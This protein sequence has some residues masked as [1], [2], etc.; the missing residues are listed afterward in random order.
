METQPELCTSAKGARPVRRTAVLHPFIFAVWPVLFV[1]SINAEF[2]R[3][4][5]AWIALLVVLG[6]AILLLLPLTA[7]LRNLRKAGAIVSL[8]L[9]LFFS[10]A[11]VYGLLWRDLP[12]YSPS[13]E[14]V[15]LLIVWALL[16]A[17][18]TA[19]AMAVRNGW[20]E[21]TTVL[22]VMSI[23]LILMSVATVGLHE[24]RA[25][26]SGQRVAQTL[27]IAEIHPVD[28]TS[29]PN[30]YYIILDSYARE[31]ILRET[32]AY[33]NS[34]FSDFLEQRGFFV[35]DLSLANY[36]QTDLSVASSLNLG[37]LDE[38]AATLGPDTRDR[39]PLEGMIQDS[40]VVRFLKLQ[41]YTVV[42]LASGYSVTDLRTSDVHISPRRSWNELEIRLLCSTPIPWLATRGTVF[43]PYAVHREK[44]LYTLDHLTNTTQPSPPYFVF[45]HVLAPHGPFVFDQQGNPVQPRGQFDLRDPIVYEEDQTAVEEIKGYTEQLTFVTNKIRTVIDTLLSQSSRPTVIILQGDHGPGHISTAK[46]AN[47]ILTRLAILNALLLPGQG[48]QDLYEEIT[49]VNT[50]RLIFDKYFGTDLEL[51]EDRS[52]FSSWERPY[53]FRD[54]T[55]QVRSYEAT[56]PSQ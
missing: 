30:I 5:Q 24:F 22:N 13:K 12:A 16:F 48:A 3:F 44:I 11:H 28:V 34:E 35:A 18:G 4:S 25:K 33:D 52:Y 51:L 38:L 15:A 21:I 47:G 32:Y 19:L 17:G 50:F 56:L 2:I 42:A 26:T 1:Y 27:P 36:P 45:A 46:D 6:L 41:G 14:S 43:D 8:F 49:P 20:Q 39:R 53:E 29:F 55:Y 31:D 9:I 37:Y 10:Y 23:A 40:S 54:V 7:I